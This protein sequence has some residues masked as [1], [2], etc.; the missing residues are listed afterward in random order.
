MGHQRALGLLYGNTPISWLRFWETTHLLGTSIA[1]AVGAA[2]GIRV[3]LDRL[4][5]E[6]QPLALVLI[7]AGVV[8][9]MGWEACVKASSLTERRMDSELPPVIMALTL[10]AGVLFW[11]VTV[12]R[13]C[14]ESPHLS[15][16]S[17]A[18]A[19]AGLLLTVLAVAIW[20]SLAGS[21]RR[22]AQLWV[23]AAA[24]VWLASA[25]RIMG[26]G[27]LPARLGSGLATLM[28]VALVAVALA[29]QR[30]G[31]SGSTP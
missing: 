24:L 20:Q 15:L 1:V 2:Y 23:T 4:Q 28:L 10:Q 3:V 29:F 5:Q 8:L 26:A 13:R 21:G 7:A 14:F 12:L 22:R 17:P 31:E 25:W 6:W 16:G 9:L 30:P 19:V 11:A 18:L 27:I